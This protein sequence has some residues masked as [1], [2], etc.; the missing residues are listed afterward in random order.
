MHTILNSC[1]S[2]CVFLRQDSIFFPTR[3]WNRPIINAKDLN[4]SR[5]DV[6]RVDNVKLLTITVSLNV[7]DIH[8]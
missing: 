7:Y 3:G 6:D 2:K 1:N 4:I 8:I 5:N